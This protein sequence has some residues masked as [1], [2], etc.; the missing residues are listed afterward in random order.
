MQKQQQEQNNHYINKCKVKC[1]VATGQIKDIQQIWVIFGINRMVGKW[2]VCT[3]K[4][5]RS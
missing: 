4:K 5:F 3:F 2:N 1:H